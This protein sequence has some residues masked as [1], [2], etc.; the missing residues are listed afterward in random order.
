MEKFSSQSYP[1]DEVMRK[2]N[3]SKDGLS[4][5]EVKKLQEE[6]GFNELESKKQK[7]TL[8][9]IIDQF[10]D[11][12]IVILILAA[13]VSGVMGEIT[14]SFIILGIVIINAIIGVAQE[15]KAG[16][17]LEALISLSAPNAKV[18]RDGK[19][20]IVPAKEIVVGDIVILETGDLIPADLR[21]TLTINLKI[22]EAALTGESVPVEKDALAILEE[23]AVIGDRINLA[24][25]SS[26]I[27]YG[28]GEGVCVAT[29]MDTE[30]G[31]I[32][33]M[34]Q[35][36]QTGTTPL[37]RKL[38]YMGKTLGIGVLAIC[39]IIFIAGMIYQ[40]D[41]FEMLLT[42]ISLAVAAI[43][44][45]LPAISTVVLAIGVQ[46]MVK[47]HAIIRTLPSVETLGS[48]T[49]ICSDKTGTL[50]QNKM[51]VLQAY[52]NKEFTDV[53]AMDTNDGVVNKMVEAAV[54]CN[55][56][57]ARVDDD[58]EITLIGDPTETA[59]IDLGI[60][61]DMPKDTLEDRL[62]RISEVP[63]DSTRKRMSTVHKLSGGGYR[64]YTKGGL[65]ELLS[66]CTQAISHNSLQAINTTTEAVAVANQK[67]AQG[68]LRVLALAYKDIDEVP[69]DVLDIESDLTFLGM[70]GMID[71]PRD[72]ARD[73]VTVCRGAGIKPVMI[74][75]DHQL[76][77]SA[78]AKD[79]GILQDG[80]RVV[81]GRELEAMSDDELNDSIRDISVYARVSPEH[82]VRIVEAWQNNNAVV[83]MTGDGVNDAPALKKADIGAAM[84]I[85][86]TDVAKEA[87]DMVLTDDN[88]ATIVSAVEEGRRIFDNILKAVLLLLS[89][90]VG[91]I[92][93]L[94][95]ATML[96]WEEPL[97]PI[98]I[99]WINLVT[100]SMPALALAVDP[101]EPDIMKRQPY[102]A[103]GRIF[104]RGMIWRIGYQ[105]VVIG[106][107]ALTAFLIGWQGDHQNLA[108]G[109]TMAFMVLAFSQ[110]VHVFNAR[111]KRHSAFCGL[112][113]NV[114]L[115]L[116]VIISGAMMV[117]VV[118]IPTL[119]D[120]FRLTSLSLG[121]WVNV[122][123]LSFAPLA[124]VELFKLLKLNTFKG[125]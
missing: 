107:L 87:A 91:E 59:L 15:N 28:R 34:I 89:C 83:A 78:I 115:W 45:G 114:L 99:L 33:Q 71:P 94:F 67:M 64:V 56:A 54:L 125:D 25:S 23:D 77:A 38:E 84:G 118:T 82:K 112:F 120:L 73:A 17:S 80:D 65:D 90:N 43:P 74:T 96:N 76:T 36:A 117:A 4:S 32:A 41:W 24:F 55:D 13:I 22:Q 98:H 69:A 75:G 104:S 108:T 79:L 42:S 31:K 116:A 109:Q 72:E 81:S 61:L 46:R 1:I 92:L 16:K 106:A 124:V 88:F 27:T 19:E 48:A 103:G 37:K 122:V 2:V 52:Y 9:M 21:L 113:S 11:A 86:G 93:T 40:K 111:S 30:V 8:S 101:A 3:S 121:N 14:D 119:A 47:R 5:C 51:T 97:L 100:D 12:M 60:M 20:I 66:C 10:K 57:R 39:V 50:T 18:K 44:E 29:G 53:K 7:S 95:V 58:G 63:F 85:V 62:P 102:E 123:L 6:F 49:V 68:A 105:G 35:S 70:V 26:M 110:L